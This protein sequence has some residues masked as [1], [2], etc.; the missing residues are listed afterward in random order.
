[1]ALTK[2]E[3]AEVLAQIE[4]LKQE[5]LNSPAVFSCTVSNGYKSDS[6]EKQVNISVS[7]IKKEDSQ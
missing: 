4:M 7:F 1:M 5:V 6:D 3:R 2:G